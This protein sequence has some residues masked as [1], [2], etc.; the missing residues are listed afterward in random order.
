MV[1]TYSSEVG[2]VRVQRSIRCRFSREPVAGVIGSSFFWL[3][4]PSFPANTIPELIAIPK[5]NPDRLNVGGASPVQQVAIELFKMMADVRMLYVPYR[6]DGPGLTDLLGGQVEIYLS[7]GAAAAGHIKMGMLRALAV[8]AARRWESLP[9]IP[10]VAE[11]I[12]G[13][14]ANSFFGV[15]APMD[16]PAEIIGRLNLE[17]K[18]GLADP[19]MKAR[20]ANLGATT[21]ALSPAEFGK[22]VG[23]ETEKWGK[24]IRAANIK[25]E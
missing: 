21:Q 14:E 18:A 7:G 2:P 9:G 6:G 10:T 20:L 12:P 11:V 25:L 17:I 8:T 5:A 1:A 16:T 15:G 19:V 23:D 4:N 24:V 13:Y 3:V 22:L